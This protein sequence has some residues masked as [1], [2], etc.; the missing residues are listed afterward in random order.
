MRVAERGREGQ[1]TPKFEF[2]RPDWQMPTSC[3]KLA[4]YPEATPLAT[5]HPLSAQ[6]SPPFLRN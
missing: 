4:T 3:N 1:P 6:F 2:G 5:G